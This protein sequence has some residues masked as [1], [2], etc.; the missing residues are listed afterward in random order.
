MIYASETN[1]LCGWQRVKAGLK[2]L[3][4]GH[5][6]TGIKFILLT[7]WPRWWN[8]FIGRSL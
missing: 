4:T 1:K 8:K 3:K 6:K 2:L 7:D 5:Y